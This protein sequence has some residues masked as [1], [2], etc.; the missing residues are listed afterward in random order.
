MK[1]IKHKPLIS[2]ECCPPWAGMPPTLGI[3]MIKKLTKMEHSLLLRLFSSH[4]ITRIMYQK[5]YCKCPWQGSKYFPNI[6]CY[7]CRLRWNLELAFLFTNIFGL[8]FIRFGLFHKCQ[9]TLKGMVILNFLKITLSL[10]CLK[11]KG[12]ARSGPL[13][14]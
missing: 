11:S 4:P 5:P 6:S 10:Q 7:F 14:F 3:H 2:E 9:P 12:Y 1:F 13:F 8:F